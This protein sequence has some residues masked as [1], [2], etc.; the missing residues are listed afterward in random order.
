MKRKVIQLAGKTYVVSLPSKWAQKCNIKKGDSLDVEETG[1]KL[2]INASSELVK[3]RADVDISGLDPMI[4]RVLGA[5]YKSGY[6]EVEVTFDRAEELEVAQEVIREEFVGYEVTRTGKKAILVKNVSNIEYGEFDTILRRIFFV[7][8]SMAEESLK[9]AEAQDRNWLRSV[10]FMDKD[11]NRYADFCRRII[12]KRGYS[13]FKVSPPMYFIVEQLEK[14]GDSYRDICNSVA[15][16][17]LSREALQYYRDINLYYRE[18]YDLYYKFDL[19]R[20]S[21]FGKRRYELKKRFEAL[22]ASAPKKELPV[23]FHLYS[24]LEKVF[25][26]N[27]PLMATKI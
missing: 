10:A 13:M 11:I 18:M 2:I 25:D 6:D 4:K 26:I 1:S 20:V 12:N 22:I 8:Q 19:K 7:I 14:I 16:V 15:G 17:K 27:G 21:E 3:A 24:I 5:V 23:T 9:A